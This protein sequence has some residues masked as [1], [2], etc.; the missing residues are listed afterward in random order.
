MFEDICQRLGRPEPAFAGERLESNQKVFLLLGGVD[1]TVEGRAT[2]Q[3]NS[4]GSFVVWYRDDN[5]RKWRLSLDRFSIL[6]RIPE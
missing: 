4:D 3:K 6:L 5:G 2:G 1:R